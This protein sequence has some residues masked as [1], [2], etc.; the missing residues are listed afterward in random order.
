MVIS[1]ILWRIPV[2]GYGARRFARVSPTTLGGR[3]ATTL[4]RVKI[5]T[6]KNA[7]SPSRNLQQRCTPRGGGFWFL[8]RGTALAGSYDKAL[9]GISTAADGSEARNRGRTRTV[10]ASAKGN[11]RRCG[12]LAG[13]KRW[14]RGGQ[15]IRAASAKRLFCG[16][17]ILYSDSRALGGKLETSPEKGNTAL[18]TIIHEVTKAAFNTSL[19]DDSHVSFVYCSRPAP[20]CEPQEHSLRRHHGAML[21]G[22][23]TPRTATEARYTIVPGH[24]G[25]ETYLR[26]G[27]CT[28]PSAQASI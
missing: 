24:L 8:A 1:S 12:S 28:S 27:T 26:Q 16:K 9:G 17:S 13:A 25:P 11:G 10:P 5:A 7:V 14:G 3:R 19:L 22:Q 2:E 4:F 20:S 18:S 21:A 23:G 6:S 15:P